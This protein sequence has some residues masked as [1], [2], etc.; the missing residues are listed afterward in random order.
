MLVCGLKFETFFFLRY[1]VTMLLIADVLMAEMAMCYP[2][3]V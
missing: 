1:E 2:L 3:S